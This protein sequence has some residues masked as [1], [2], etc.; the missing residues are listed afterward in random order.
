MDAVTV[1]GSVLIIAR[2]TLAQLSRGFSRSRQRSTSVSIC[3]SGADS[4]VKS[5]RGRKL[6]PRP[7][8]RSARRTKRAQRPVGAQ[9]GPPYL[10]RW[11]GG[12]TD[13]RADGHSL[14]G[15]TSGRGGG[16]IVAV[17]FSTV[18][19]ENLTIHHL[20]LNQQ[21]AL[22]FRFASLA[23]ETDE[24]RKEPRISPAVESFNG[25]PYWILRIVAP[26]G[27]R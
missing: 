19:R 21:R 1:L 27:N 20:Y 15:P 23:E 5:P 25:A 4:R 12:R 2:G 16:L 26:S 14:A 13:G 22:N 24:R 8:R 6:K 9:A 18:S 3:S 17:D 10:A 11:S 7:R